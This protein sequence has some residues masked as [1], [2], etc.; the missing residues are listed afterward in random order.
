MPDIKSATPADRDAVLAGTMY[1]RLARKL[2]VEA[3]LP[4]A[5]AAVRK[6]P[7]GA[8]RHIDQRLRRSPS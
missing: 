6:S 2:L 3:G 7:D 5:A 4:R 8:V 1:L